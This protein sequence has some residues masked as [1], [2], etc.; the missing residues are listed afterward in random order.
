MTKYNDLRRLGLGVNQ[1]VRDVERVK[2]LLDEAHSLVFGKHEHLSK[3]IFKAQDEALNVIV[4]EQD[5]YDERT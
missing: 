1:E 3:L 4:Q 2:S 5:K